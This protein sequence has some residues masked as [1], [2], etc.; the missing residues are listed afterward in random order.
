M[1]R[2]RLILF[3]VIPVVFIGCR[4]ALPDRAP[5][6]TATQPGTSPK[7]T[8]PLF[9]AKDASARN[10]AEA[11]V[12]GDPGIRP[13]QFSVDLSPFARKGQIAI[14]P[15][16]SLDEP[17][18]FES[19]W[20]VHLA[21]Q[22]QQFEFRIMTV[23]GYKEV[24]KQKSTMSFLEAALKPGVHDVDV[25]QMPY[26]IYRSGGINMAARQELLQG[27]GW[28]GLRWIGGFGQDTACAPDLGYI[29]EGITN[30]G[31]YFIMLRAALSHAAVQRRWDHG[32]T[33]DEEALKINKLLAA[34]LVKA[35]PRSFHP[36]L[37]G[38]DKVVHSL[39]FLQ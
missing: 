15:Y 39:K 27:D 23:T 34:D 2:I 9:A 19:A 8:S 30:D 14:V 31:R 6:H 37:D 18:D 25:K 13:E 32:C 35:S 10:V 17:D 5:V 7:R 4:T 16:S 24:F 29:F 22:K 3:A 21:V 12:V 28:R 26:S 38:L 36:S 1:T 11:Q 20:P 33:T